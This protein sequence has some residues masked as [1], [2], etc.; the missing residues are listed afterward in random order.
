MRGDQPEPRREAST[1]DLDQINEA[2]IAAE[3]QD[4]LKAVIRFTNQTS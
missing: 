2:L 4:M 1:F 3:R